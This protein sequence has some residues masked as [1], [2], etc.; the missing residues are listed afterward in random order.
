MVYTYDLGGN[1]LGKTAY[2][3]T[4]EDTITEAAVHTDT[5]TYDEPNWKDQLTA[6]NGAQIQYDGTG[7]PVNDGEWIYTWQHGQ[8]LAQMSKDG[9]AV[10]FVYNEDGLRVQ[11]TATSTG[12]TK[13]ILHGKNIV[14][15]TNGQNELHFFY[16]AQG[17]AAAVEYNGTSYRYLHNLQGDVIA[18][19]DGNGNR[20]VEYS[21]DAWGKP[22]QK[23]GTMADTLGTLQPFRYRGYVWDEETG[24]YY[25]RSRYYRPEWDRFVSA[26]C[27]MQTN[28]YGYCSNNPISYVDPDGET[29]LGNAASQYWQEHA[30]YLAAA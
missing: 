17:K 2:P 29:E 13:Y 21:Y 3:F 23:T 28:L 25:L 26:D 30:K 16:N 9:E 22:I 8:Q 27:V 14:H 24:L 18:L 6:Y 5:Y 10:S 11:K 19:I 12:T 1:I 15:L 7:N 4:E 20:V